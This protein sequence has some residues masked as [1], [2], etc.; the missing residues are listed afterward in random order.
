MD[1]LTF[2]HLHYCFF[3]VEKLPSIILFKSATI[4]S[5]FL[6]SKFNAEKGICHGNGLETHT[7]LAISAFNLIK[8][9]LFINTRN[10]FCYLAN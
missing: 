7:R 8:M 4:F 6:L 3:H 9:A 2:H 1:W 10:L 5:Y